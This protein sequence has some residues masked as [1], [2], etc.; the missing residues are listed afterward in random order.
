MSPEE[1]RERWEEEESIAQIKGCDFSHIHVRYEKEN[2][3]PFCYHNY[4]RRKT[5]KE[6]NEKLTDRELKL[7]AVAI[8]LYETAMQTPDKFPG[9]H[10]H[11][12]AAK[13]NLVLQVITDLG[14][15]HFIDA[16]EDAYRHSTPLDD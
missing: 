14:P 6:E 10:C 16:L 15:K 2:T 4:Y 5:M 9:F 12:D 8:G 13:I 3:L 7:C 1:L 11:I